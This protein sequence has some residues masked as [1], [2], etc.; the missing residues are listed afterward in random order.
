[1]SQDELPINSREWWED[2]FQRHWDFY[3]GG[4]QTSHFMERLLV[5]LPTEV[6]AYLTAH[7][8]QILDWGCAQG[9]G[10]ALL[11]QSFPTCRVAGLDCSQ[12]ALERAQ[13][14]YPK[15]E[16][17]YHPDGTIPRLFDVIVCSNTL[18]HF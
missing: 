9:Q 18:E 14:L 10:A 2:Y 8:R 1:M 11:Q 6:L 4:N 7:P 16:W 17:I 13:A 3:D 12:T 15:Q 5:N